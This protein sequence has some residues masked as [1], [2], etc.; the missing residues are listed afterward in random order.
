MLELFHRTQI[1]YATRMF[2]FPRA[3]ERDSQADTHCPD[4]TVGQEVHNEAVKLDESY[5]TQYYR[6]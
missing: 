1:L 3:K 4:L 6:Q 2:S 5:Y